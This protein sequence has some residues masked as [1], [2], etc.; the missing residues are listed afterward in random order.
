MLDADV[1][2]SS[3]PTVMLAHPFHQH[4][5][6][7]RDKNIVP[8]TVLNTD[9]TLKAPPAP[10]TTQSTSAQADPAQQHCV[11]QWDASFLGLC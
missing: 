2:V 3:S 5:K 1:A 6:T 8:N 10:V 4:P 11:D 7:A 9:G